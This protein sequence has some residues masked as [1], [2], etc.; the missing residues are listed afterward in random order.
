MS[1]KR[2]RAGERAQHGGGDS[3]RDRRDYSSSSQRSQAAHGREERRDRF[4]SERHRSDDRR[5]SRSE[6]RPSNSNGSSSGG[7]S[8]SRQTISHNSFSGVFAQ[9]QQPALP[10]NWNPANPLN[11]PPEPPRPQ[12]VQ[13]RGDG[14]RRWNNANLSSKNVG[15]RGRS[16]LGGDHG[17]TDFSQCLPVPQELPNELLKTIFAT[18]RVTT[19]DGVQTK[20]TANVHIEEG[21]LLMSLIKANGLKKCL[22]VGFAFGVSALFMCE[23]LKA[24]SSQSPSQ[25]DCGTVS[26]MSPTTATQPKGSAEPQK[27]DNQEETPGISSSSVAVASPKREALTSKRG[28]TELAASTDTQLDCVKKSPGSEKVPPPEYFLYSIDPNQS[29]KWKSIGLSNIDQAGFSK[30]H[31]CFEDKSFN[32]M[33]QLLP[34]LTGKL[35]LVFI[36]GWHTFDYTLVD[37]FYADLLVRPGG[38]IVFDDALHKGPQQVVRSLKRILVSC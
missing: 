19:Q 9:G 26:S 12:Y 14:G 6:R 10:R 25:Q 20:L 11:R 37:G 21:H 32:T 30:Y 33:P 18:K 4:S 17:G 28:E 5:H 34:E 31:Q 1:Q 3:K 24:V 7:S 35:D 38:F 27:C 13:H 22:E 2:S 36:D 8:S 15:N 16:L 23:A 29:G